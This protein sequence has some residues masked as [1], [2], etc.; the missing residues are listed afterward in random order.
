[1]LDPH[2]QETQWHPEWAVLRAADANQ[3]HGKAKVTKAPQD[4][5]LD[6]RDAEGSPIAQ[7][8]SW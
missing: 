8:G 7:E 3:P 5:F 4:A 6:L 1:M 2:V